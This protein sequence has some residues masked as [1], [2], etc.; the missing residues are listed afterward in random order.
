MN[1][2]QFKGLIRFKVA[3]QEE[4]PKWAQQAIS[5]ALSAA[6]A[7]PESLR[8]Q[9]RIATDAREN[10]KEIK[11]DNGETLK[12]H[13]KSAPQ[14]GKDRSGRAYLTAT[15]VYSGDGE[16]YKF[17]WV[18]DSVPKKMQEV[19]VKHDMGK[20]VAATTIGLRLENAEV[21]LSYKAKGSP[22]PSKRDKELARQKRRAAYLNGKGGASGVTRRTR[23]CHRLTAADL[24]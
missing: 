2:T 14:F 9:C 17:R 19:A 18:G 3:G 15:M 13:Y 11:L 12:L 6:E 8:F 24:A 7:P 22:H 5:N 4:L 23:F 1:T 20:R 10:L 16:S 21:N